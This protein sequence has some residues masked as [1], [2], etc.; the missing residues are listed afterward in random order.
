MA[1]G[2]DEDDRLLLRHSTA[3]RKGLTIRMVR[4]M[5][6]AYERA[7]RLAQQPGV[8]LAGLVSHRFPLAD[9]PTAFAVNA[10]YGDRIVKGV[11]EIS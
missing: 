11:I 4:R 3:R 8:D 10:D 2:I 6:H 1:V 5:K 9:A 7:I